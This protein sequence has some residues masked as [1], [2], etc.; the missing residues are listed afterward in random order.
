MELLHHV[1]THLD[2]RTAGWKEKGLWILLI[3]A[4]IPVPSI[5]MI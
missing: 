5:G 3:Q 1:V 4:R 2:M